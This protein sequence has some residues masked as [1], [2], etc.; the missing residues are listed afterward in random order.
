MLKLLLDQDFDHDIIRG[1]C[2]RIPELNYTTAYALGL[3][4]APDPQLLLRAAAEGRILLTH[5]E[6]SMPGHFFALINSGET[7][8]G[9]VIVPR[10]LSMREVIDDL[11][12]IVNC[13][14]HEDWKDN[15]R[16]LPF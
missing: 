1:L 3:S 10:R 5:D 12:L 15:Y 9:V 14:S 13:T 7:L 2:Q 4:D 11:Y 8:E 6:L 16:V